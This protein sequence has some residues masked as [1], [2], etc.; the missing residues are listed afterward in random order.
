MNYATEMERGTNSPALAGTFRL[1]MGMLMLIAGLY[2]WVF[3]GGKGEGLGL[4]F[5]I[6]SPFVILTDKK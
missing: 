6:C 5:L 4:L 2:I 3:A 1:L